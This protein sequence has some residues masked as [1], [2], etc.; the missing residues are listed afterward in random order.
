MTDAIVT[1]MSEYRQRKGVAE[2]STWT[3]HKVETRHELLRM[4]AKHG[5]AEDPQLSFVFPNGFDPENHAEDN[6]E[7]VFQEGVR[8]GVFKISE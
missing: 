6:I 4:V 7:L 8:R 3:D 1:H 5:G 2:F